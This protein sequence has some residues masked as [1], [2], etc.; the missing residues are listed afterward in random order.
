MGGRT[1][2]QELLLQDRLAI[3]S[4]A[5]I[6]RCAHARLA[7]TTTDLVALGFVEVSTLGGQVLHELHYTRG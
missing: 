6:G 4:L 3:A 7:A 5:P 2:L 1:W